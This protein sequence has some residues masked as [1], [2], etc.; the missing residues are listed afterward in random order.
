M[1][2]AS[3][4]IY[5]ANFS[6]QAITTATDLFEITVAADRPVV[7][8]GMTLGQTTDLGD[9]AEEVLMIGVYRDVTAGST[10]TAATEYTYTNTSLAATATAAVVT[11]RGTASTGGTLIDII[12]WNIRVPLTWIPIPE[13]R[14]KFTNLAAEGPVSSFRLIAAPADSITAS[15]VLYWTEI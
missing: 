7:I 10:G 13:M 5:A 2:M 3:P 6:A 12:P 11:L 4:V 1:S 9:A 8:Y 14:P 15:G